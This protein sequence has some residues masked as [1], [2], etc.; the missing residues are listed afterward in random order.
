M[1]I[2]PSILAE[3]TKDFLP[4]IRQAESF[5]DYI[6]IDLMDGLFVPT[7]SFPPEDI[8]ALSTS[9][10][11]E[12][13]LMFRDPSQVADRLSNHGLKKVIFH[14]EAEGDCHGIIERLKRRGIAAGVAINPETEI[15]LLA[16]FAG[17]ADTFLFLTVEP[18]RY[19]SPFRADV[20]GKVESARTL[21]GD[22]EIA[23]DGG[24]SL[25]NLDLFVEAGVDYACVGSRI[26]LQGNPS[27]NYV[28][29]L[30]KIK[31]LEGVK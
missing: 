17:E 15:S 2:V 12:V 13:H 1:K 16:E 11:F 7:R 9:L 20:I 30:N 4:F 24:V 3:S 28:A 31:Q 5:A 26:F 29:F 27:E 21:Y 19:G 18:G 8:N 23:V 6:Q 25:D 10:S 22:M 14:V